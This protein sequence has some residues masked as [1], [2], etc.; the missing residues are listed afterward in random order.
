MRTC[1]AGWTLTN[2][3][4]DDEVAY[5]MEI[6]FEMVYASFVQALLSNSVN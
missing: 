3:V 4:L 6:D 2:S 1:E 5:C